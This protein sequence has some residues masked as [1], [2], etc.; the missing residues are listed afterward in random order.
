MPLQ[1]VAS[2]LLERRLAAGSY[3]EVWFAR[4]REGR[5][6]A[7]KLLHESVMADADSLRRFDRESRT[8]ISLRHPNLVAAIESGTHA[9]RAFLAS[10]FVPG[11]SVQD[12]LDREG[13]L[14]L[15]RA[16]P[17][18]AGI[19]RGL[20]AIHRAGMVHRDLKPANV[21]LDH[22]GEPK[23][24]DL[25][26]V[27]PTAVQRTMLTVEGEIVGTPAYMAPEQI[28]HGGDVDIRTDLYAV[29]VMMYRCLAGELPFE[30]RDVLALLHAQL[31]Q[32][33]P[34]PTRK[35]PLPAEMS[36]LVQKLMGGA[37][38][39]RRFNCIHFLV[40]I[41]VNCED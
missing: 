13:R 24:A 8:A 39:H 22:S 17:I 23:I 34:D 38:W 41:H 27:R 29:G 19:L 21:L 36:Q 12:L 15:N 40:S 3:G 6:I 33:T 25:G 26:L 7:L 14:S 11:G 28:T 35:V 4:D 32:P 10:E 2:Y 30:A 18:F 20:D 37:V 1:R 16:L 5:P 31:H 9:G